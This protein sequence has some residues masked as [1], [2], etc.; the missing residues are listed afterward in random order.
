MPPRRRPSRA[1]APAVLLAALVALAGMAAA[2]A[3]ARAGDAPA[4]GVAAP[5]AA[6]DAA[7]A[8]APPAADGDAG[9]PARKPVRVVVGSDDQKEVA[10]VIFRSPPQ[11]PY[12][13]TNF[14]DGHLGLTVLDRHVLTFGTVA[15]KGLSAAELPVSRPQDADADAARAQTEADGRAADAAR[16]ADQAAVKKAA[17]EGEAAGESFSFRQARGPMLSGN[18][19]RRRAEE[20]TD[21][22]F[23]FLEVGGD[24]AGAVGG[25]AAGAV[26]GGAEKPETRTFLSVGNL[27]VDGEVHVRRAAPAVSRIPQWA[28][29]HDDD[30]ETAA[31]RGNWFPSDNGTCGF[32]DVHLG[33][34][35]N[36]AGHTATRTY[37]DLPPHQYVRVEARYHFIDA[38]AGET[39]FARVDKTPAWTR[40]HHECNLVFNPLCR[41][42]NV[43]GDEE[44]TDAL[45]QPVRF[46][47]AH[48]ATSLELTFGSTLS[49][50]PCEASW[51]IDDVRLS[52]L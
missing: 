24:G 36:F 9:L 11:D 13:L 28:V 31:S 2:A 43:C 3:A 47:L 5:A 52:V 15:A 39:A 22:V 40:T 17:D 21:M 19:G 1:P 27:T 30:F 45:S 29:L 51:G 33:G 41:G 6:P 12:I 7:P 14:R 25:A 35:C 50:N 18:G 37:R 49:R 20:A 16:D 10:R 34:V 44:A 48:N 8:Q 23:T 46:V 26:A 32:P 4:Q 42:L 38:W